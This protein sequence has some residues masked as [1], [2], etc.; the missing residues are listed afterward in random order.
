MASPGGDTSAAAFLHSLRSALD[1]PG[2]SG[3]QRRARRAR[4]RRGE[5][6]SNVPLTPIDHHAWPDRS[7]GCPSA[8]PDGPL[9]SMCRYRPT[10]DC[11]YGPAAHRSPR[12]PSGRVPQLR[13]RGISPVAP[14]RPRPV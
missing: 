9:A 1:A 3:E 2:R 12:R 4:R 14:A 10:L 11:G 6:G 8:P 5:P 7:T 13:G